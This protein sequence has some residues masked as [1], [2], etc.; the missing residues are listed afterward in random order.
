MKTFCLFDDIYNETL[1]AFEEFIQSLDDEEK[2]VELVIMSYGGSIFDGLAIAD[3]IIESG[4]KFTARVLGCAM[5]AAAVIACACDRI[6]MSDLDAI[7]I[8]S[9]RSC[10]GYVDEGSH[11][12]NASMLKII[13]RR[14]PEYTEEDLMKDHFFDADEALKAGLIDEIIRADSERAELVARWAAHI[15]SYGGK[16][17]NEE[18]KE[19]GK[20]QVEEKE[21]EV[22]EEVDPIQGLI[23]A[24]QDLQNRVAA[25][26]AAQNS[27]VEA[28][29]EDEEKKEDIIAAGMRKIYAGIGAVCK[30]VSKD[31]PQK[32]PESEK[33]RLDAIYGDF[34]RF[35]RE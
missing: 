28:E 15:R 10:F 11:I 4:R 33:A 32:T 2:D 7:M 23:E 19:L 30:P 22:A 12:A 6:V 35:N 20:E 31:V 3:R 27:A 21:I 14:L 9:A 1:K 13:N 26:E 8:H 18:V 17:M 24:V 29:C 16:V 5:S 25:L 34:A